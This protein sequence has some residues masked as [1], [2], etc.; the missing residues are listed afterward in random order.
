M[1]HVKTPV[2]NVGDG[3]FIDVA[4]DAYEALIAVCEAAIEYHA[5]HAPFTAP[6]TLTRLAEMAEA[7]LAKARGEP[8]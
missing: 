4:K 3:K 2:K 6:V 8:K 5:Q 7:A 1:K